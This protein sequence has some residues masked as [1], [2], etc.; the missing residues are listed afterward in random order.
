LAHTGFQEELETVR[1]ALLA[2][3]E[4]RYAG[5]ENLWY[6]LLSLRTVL[7]ADERELF[8]GLSPVFDGGL[9]FERALGSLRSTQKVLLRLWTGVET[10]KPLLLKRHLEEG[11]HV[12]WTLPPAG[13]GET[14]EGRISV[15]LW[16]RLP[17]EYSGTLDLEPAG[18]ENV[19]AEVLS[20][21]YNLSFTNG[22]LSLAGINSNEQVRVELAW[23][24][25]LAEKRSTQTEQVG[26]ATVEEARLRTQVRFSSLRPGLV[27][28]V[29]EVPYY[30]L[31]TASSTRPLSAYSSRS[32]GSS[33][34]EATVDAAKGEGEV[35]FEE[36]IDSPFRTRVSAEGGVDNNS[37]VLRLFLEG[38][39][40][41]LE[42][43]SHTRVE[44]VSC[45]SGKVEAK[46]PAGGSAEASLLGDLLTVRMRAPRLA[47]GSSLE[48]TVFL[49]CSRMAQLAE[50]KLQEAESLLE[51]VH[52]TAEGADTE[53]AEEK[54]EQARVLLES[55]SPSKALPLIYDSSQLLNTALENWNKLSLEQAAVE[56]RARQAGDALEELR[57]LEVLP[58]AQLPLGK[59]RESLAQARAELAEK[60]LTAAGVS[61]NSAESS[62]SSV[63]AALGKELDNLSKSCPFEECSEAREAVKEAQL[64]LA[65]RAWSAFLESYD[66]AEGLVQEAQA[67]RSKQNAQIKELLE[68][69]PGVREEFQSAS[70]AFEQAFQIVEGQEKD[71][72]SSQAYARGSKAQKEGTS[73][74]R[75]LENAWEKWQQRGDGGLE[76]QT[77]ELLQTRKEKVG[78]AVVEL[79]EAVESV[80]EQAKLELEQA[81]SRAPNS[82]EVTGAEEALGEGRAFTAW[83]LARS[84]QAP[85]TPS[86]PVSTG[87]GLGW[88]VGAGAAA[89]L[90]TLAWVFSRGPPRK[91]LRE[92]E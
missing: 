74:L 11:A 68:L 32:A 52:A 8:E 69:V 80:Q 88:A 44:R 54:L 60:Q 23:R 28:V 70:T 75:E 2:E 21:S 38:S 35:V 90:I 86:G 85:E 14:V 19:D 81:K 64:H 10:R 79:R 71:Q 92:V 62:L 87:E 17:L 61:L 83:L 72:R 89:I 15:E 22:R 26:E 7:Q 84:A 56:E 91:E 34:I 6:K 5:L 55:G 46:S 40:A 77:V 76:A 27:K 24:G 41:D 51:Q 4:T 16:N 82:Q 50:E 67:E 9:R 59:A 63:S 36:S 53:K 57:E 73:E 58:A 33:R 1:T 25:V 39:V 43:V 47:R 78:Q 48:F 45:P 66:K 37:L 49:E 42:K 30:A 3:A 31:L 20:S 65:S 13:L 29:H 12:E 18:L